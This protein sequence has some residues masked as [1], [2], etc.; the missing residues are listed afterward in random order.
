MLFE[1]SRQVGSIP[2]ILVLG[3]C[4]TAT[5][6]FLNLLI[7]QQ[8]F[9]ESVVI[10]VKQDTLDPIGHARLI[11]LPRF[12]F[13]AQDSCLCCGMHG[14]LGDALRQ[15]FF[16]ALNDRSKRLDRVLIESDSIEASQLAHTLRH[17]PFLG[18]RYIHQM[19]FRV[20]CP[21]QPSET[22]FQ[23][24]GE[25]QACLA[26]LKGLDPVSNQSRQVLILS[27]PLAQFN[28]EQFNNW[29]AQVKQEL[30]YKEVFYLSADG[31]KDL[32]LL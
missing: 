10:G 20:V 9:S 4:L 5:R 18:Q 6:L 27:L 21:S 15:I 29:S 2:I 32:N 24:T 13:T 30:P 26:G 8:D 19:T 3:E 31:V 28:A 23:K 17:T 11:E 1:T 12:E 22:F 7:A 16:Q 25:W 14:A